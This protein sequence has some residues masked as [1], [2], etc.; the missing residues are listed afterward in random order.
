MFL[1]QAVNIFFQI[2]VYLIFGRV[3]LSWFARPGDRVYPLYR[4]LIQLTEPILAPFRR[5]SDRFMRNSGI[6]ISPM[7][8][9]FAIWFVRALIIKLLFILF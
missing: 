5:L 1:V 9:I 6:D 2:V 4:M 8:A 7:I 3:I